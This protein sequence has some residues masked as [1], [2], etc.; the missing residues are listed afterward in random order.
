MLLESRRL[1]ERA[2]ELASVQGSAPGLRLLQA[3][4]LARGPELQLLPEPARALASGW[5][6]EPEPGRARE[7]VPAPSGWPLPR[8]PVPWH[9]CEPDTFPADPGK[10]RACR[11]R[12]RRC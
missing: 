6:W 1:L 8:R 2:R 9:P 7:L 12:L 4:A 10:V 3:R 11:H 5:A